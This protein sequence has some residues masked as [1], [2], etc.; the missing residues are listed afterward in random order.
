VILSNKIK[1]ICPTLADNFT[2]EDTDNVNIAKYHRYLFGIKDYLGK[3]KFYLSKLH[4]SPIIKMEHQNND[5]IINLNDVPLQEHAFNIS[6][7]KKYVDFQIT[8]IFKNINYVKLY[9]VSENGTT[10]P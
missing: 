5:F 7:I 8:I 3:L 2:F 6:Q 10:V 4:D 1:D 9:K